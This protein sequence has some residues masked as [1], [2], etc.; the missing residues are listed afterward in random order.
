MGYFDQYN[1]NQ[2]PFNTMGTF[3]QSASLLYGDETQSN[4][5][6]ANNKSGLASMGISTGDQ[7]SWWGDTFKSFD[8]LLPTAAGLAGMYMQWDKLQAEKNKARDAH[9]A[10]AK[11][12]NNQLVRANNLGKSIYGDSYKQDQTHVKKSTV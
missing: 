12:Y 2:D 8:N 5:P 4:M 1:Q 3:D 9:N 7:N 10:N 6:Y 11:M